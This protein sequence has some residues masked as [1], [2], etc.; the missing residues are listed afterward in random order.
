MQIRQVYHTLYKQKIFVIGVFFVAVCL[1]IAGHVSAVATADTHDGKLVTIYDRGQKRVVLTHARTIRDALISAKVTVSRHDVV[2]PAEDSLLVADDYTVNIYRARPVIVTDGAVRQ[3]VMT[4]A[5]TPEAIVETTGGTLRSE[6]KVTLAASNNIVADGAS[7]VL[8][9]DRATPLTL[10]LYGVQTTIYTQ[11]STVDEM[12][13]Q[14]NIKL[15]PRDTVL[16][17]RRAPIVANMIVEIWRDGAQTATVEEDVMYPVRTIQDADQLIGY[18]AIQTPGAVGKKN[19]VYEITA[20]GGKE[21]GRKVIQTVVTQEPKE[22]VEIVGVKPGP[23]ALTKTKGAQTYT[24]SKG[25]SHRETYYDLNMS[26]VMGA[27]GGGVYTIRADGA[28]VDKDGYILV[29]ANLG[30]YPRCSVVE[31]SMGLGK[32]YDTGGF[33][34][35]YPHGFDLATDW[36]DGDGR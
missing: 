16:V 26:I 32:V 27:C 10:K 8:T 19:V 14:K 28:K 20:Q 34:A 33:A 15:A 3:K 24:D 30:N 35:R 18:H 9:I 13:K 6:D 2:E 22:Q 1:V 11:A 12:L 36:T 5:Q 4:A 21:I 25:V 31:T 23:N 17:D 29:A 7:T